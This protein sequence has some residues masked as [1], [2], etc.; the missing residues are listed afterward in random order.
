MIGVLGAHPTLRMAP[1]PTPDTTPLPP[2]LT[3]ALGHDGDWISSWWT[4]AALVVLTALLIALSL[5]T[6]GARRLAVSVLAVL[7]LSLGVTIGVNA[8]VGY[9]PDVMAAR[10]LLVGQGLLAAN[11]ATV[12]R[13]AGDVRRGAVRIERIPAP[14]PLRMPRAS[15][16]I[17][18][19]PGY[20]PS[21]STRYPV[22]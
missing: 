12:G 3:A 17:Y 8:Y 18:T 2:A 1:L 7:S 19:P 9:L 16:W 22:A 13:R 21:G 11:P 4:V 6:R 14:A 20:D 15:T 10:F 5:R